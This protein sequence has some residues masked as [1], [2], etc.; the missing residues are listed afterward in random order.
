MK[1]IS[2]NKKILF[3]GNASNTMRLF[4]GDLMAHLVEKGSDVYG[5]APRIHDSDVE[6]FNS[7]GVKFVVWNFEGRL[8]FSI[9]KNVI[10]IQ[11]LYRQT[12]KIKPDLIFVY[13][14]KPI[15]FSSLLKI[16]WLKIPTVAL[17]E[18][19]GRLLAWAVSDQFLSLKKYSAKLL[20]FLLRWCLVKHDR[21]I[22]LNKMDYKFVVKS[23]VTGADSVHLIDGIGVDTKIFCPERSLVVNQDRPSLIFGFVGRLVLEKGV[24][25]FL[26]GARKFKES[27]GISFEIWGELDE[28]LGFTRSEFSRLCEENGVLWRGATSDPTEIYRDGFVLTLPTTYGEG[29]PRVIMEAL[30]SGCPVITVRSTPGAGTSFSDGKAGF[31]MENGSPSELVRVLLK[32]IEAKVSYAE[33]ARAARKDALS[34]YKLADKIREFEKIIEMGVKR[35]ESR[36]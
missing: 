34:R 19:R 18:G 24:L 5:F 33:F 17:L 13:F 35:L 15:I 25:C 12:I 8:S 23:S 30:S 11:D 22:V 36:G 21:I 32:F 6:Y 3:V 20:L 7:I 16:W 27:T 4:R 26:D 31:Y 28:S 1:S 10:A 14:L 9:T 2:G 29:L